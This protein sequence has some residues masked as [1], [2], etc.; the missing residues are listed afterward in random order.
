[1]LYERSNNMIVTFQD[2][3]GVVSVKINDEQG[4]T[5]GINLKDSST[6]AWF[7][8]INEKDYIVDTK[9]LISIVKEN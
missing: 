3:L 1:M 4:V 9:H 7:T 8:D 6:R 5:F 2:E